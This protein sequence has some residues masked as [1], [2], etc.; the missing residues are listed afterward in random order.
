MNLISLDAK[1]SAKRVL[2]RACRKGLGSPL[3]MEHGKYE[4]SQTKPCARPY[5][6]EPFGTQVPASAHYAAP[7]AGPVLHF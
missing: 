7:P 5:E 3:V 1:P 2:I 6:W 4:V